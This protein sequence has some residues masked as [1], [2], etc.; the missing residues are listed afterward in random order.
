MKHQYSAVFVDII[1]NPI[2]MILERL[3]DKSRKKAAHT[4]DC[5]QMTHV[6]CDGGINLFVSRWLDDDSDI[7]RLGE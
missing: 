2:S 1:G 7:L 4:Y 6:A 5:H 3:G